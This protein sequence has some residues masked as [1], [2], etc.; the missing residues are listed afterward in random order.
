[1]EKL[2]FQT[3]VKSEG[4]IDDASSDDDE[5]VCVE[6]MSVKKCDHDL[7]GGMSLEVSTMSF[8]PIR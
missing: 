2:G 8:I 4:V 5:L 1:M 3:G 6:W 7:V